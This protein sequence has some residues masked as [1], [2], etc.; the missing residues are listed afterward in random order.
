MGETWLVTGANRGIGLAVTQV[1]LGAG[2]RVFAA[3]RN[4]AQATELGDLKKTHAQAL[5]VL[6]MDA[7]SDASVEKAAQAAAAKAG[8]LDVLINMAGILP[9][10]HDQPLEKL[11]LQQC[12]EAFETNALGPLRASRA[13]L[14]LLR[15]SKN[16]RVVNVTSGCGSLSGKADGHFYAYGTSKA[17][18][19]MLSR[20]FAFE[21]KKENITCVALDPGWVKTDMGGPNA[22][23]TPEESSSAIVRTVKGLTLAD[24]SK[25]I[26]NDGKELGW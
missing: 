17:A 10:P 26:Y 16:P 4:P 23:L 19:N 13:F 21:F 9:R 18:L 25:F 3:C 2:D 8:S 24:T 20:T 12:R 6:E 15:K 11:D 1:L 14:P 5:E 22:W 7:A